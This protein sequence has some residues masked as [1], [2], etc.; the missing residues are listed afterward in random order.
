MNSSSQEQSSVGRQ[1]MTDDSACVEVGEQGKQRTHLG[2]LAGLRFFAALAVLIGHLM[3]DPDGDGAGRFGLPH[4]PIM[5]G[6]AAVS[7]FFVLSGFILTYVYK[8]KLNRK[9]LLR[10]Y[11][12]RW[13]RIWPLHLTCMIIA[14]YAFS[15]SIDSQPKFWTNLTLLHSWI[16]QSD[17]VFSF[18]GVSWSIS[19][20]MFFYF[21]FPFF[22]FGGQKSFWIKYLA[23]WVIVLGA[24]AGMQVLGNNPDFANYDFERV[25]QAN[26]LLRL[27]EFCTGMAVGFLFFNRIGSGASQSKTSAGRS[28]V[29]DTIV[30]ILALGLI[31]AFMFSYRHFKI[32]WLIRNADWGG[33]PMALWAQYVGM[34]LVFA[35]VIYVF[36]RSE[37]FFGRLFGSKWLVFGGE[38]SYAIYM[39]HFIVIVAMDRLDWSASNHSPWVLG[40]CA[41][42]ISICMA[43]LLYKLVEMPSKAFWLGL[44][45]RDFREAFG[46]AP[47]Q[48]F[49]YF[50][51]PLCWTCLIALAGAIG[52]AKLQY[53]PVNLSP[54]GWQVIAESHAPYVGVEFGDVIRLK[55]V[56][57]TPTLEGIEVEMVWQKLKPFERL[58][59]L[60]ICDAQGNVL[61]QM[62]P[63]E[64]LFRNA[65][66]LQPVIE[67]FLIPNAK[68]RN[69]KI[70]QI[71]IGF[72]ST[73]TDPKTGK[74]LPML[75]A[76][77][78]LRGMFNFRLNIVGENQMNNIRRQWEELENNTP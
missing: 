35:L 25:A 15:V 74:V 14:I 31:P 63:E 54:R 38:I 68:L 27:P 1:E 16:P 32:S 17:W 6:G 20:E 55:G 26:P 22:L 36:A 64:E 19:T 5:L 10:F 58:R 42:L 65:P 39:I 51:S 18:N 49:K 4:Y 45:S 3:S 60:H 9:N 53:T 48:F 69:R 57:A 66:L 40:G 77:K 11:F 59:F 73:E 21:M 8:D 56:K 13:A 44:Y 30:E 70:A 37:G 75:K 7:F 33:L 76:S 71:G 61:D 24:V 41:I 67:S 2:A 28:Y 46:A 43:C 62:R 72:Y 47:A 78:G 50:R 52:V 34:F 12:K 23:L 29:L